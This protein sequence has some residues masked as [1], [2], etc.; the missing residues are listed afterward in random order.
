MLV[1]FVMF[2][3]TKGQPL[4]GEGVYAVFDNG[5]VRAALPIEFGELRQE[6]HPYATAPIRREPISEKPRYQSYDNA[7]RDT[8]VDAD[9]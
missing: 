3:D 5:M 6:G 7:L 4:D 2:K 9:D 1:G 8:D